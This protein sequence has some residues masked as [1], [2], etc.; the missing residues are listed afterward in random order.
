MLKSPLTRKRWLFALSVLMLTTLATTTY[1]HSVQ[2]SNSTSSPDSIPTF[3]TSPT[4]FL[5]GMFD[6]VG[7][8]DL[9]YPNDPNG[10]FQTMMDDIK[11]FG[12]NAIAL[13]NG[14]ASTLN[15]VLALS[16]ATN[17]F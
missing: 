8:L 11:R 2:A 10:G 1:K 17:Y 14:D 15:R 7:A 16:D 4:S 5:F 13:N 9:D 12:F 3:P 6:A